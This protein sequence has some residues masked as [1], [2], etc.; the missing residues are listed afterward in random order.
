M[1]ISTLHSTGSPRMA[2]IAFEFH[3]EPQYADM[4]GKA[5]IWTAWHK[6]SCIKDWPKLKERKCTNI[7]SSSRSFQVDVAVAG[8]RC[9]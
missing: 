7:G 9:V 8:A 1:I 5:M 6:F 2:P 4:I 3:T